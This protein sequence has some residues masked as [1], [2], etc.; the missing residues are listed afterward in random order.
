M[1]NQTAHGV[2]IVNPENGSIDYVNQ[3]VTDRLGYT[4]EELQKKTIDDIAP[5]YFSDEPIS[6]QLNR[7]IDSSPT[8][9]LSHHLTKKNEFI[10]VRMQLDELI[11]GD[12]TYIL[13]MVRELEPINDNGDPEF[14]DTLRSR[15]SEDGVGSNIDESMISEANISPSPLDFGSDL[16]IF[17]EMRDEIYVFD[18]E[19]GKIL[20]AN[21]TAQQRLGYRREELLQMKIIDFVDI[22]ETIDDWHD[23]IELYRDGDPEPVEGRHFPKNRSSYPVEVNSTLIENEGRQYLISI[24][25]DISERKQ[26][27]RESKKLFNAVNDA[28]SVHDLETFRMID[29]NDTIC[30]M[31]GHDRQTILEK[32]V[33]EFSATEDGFTQ[34][35]AQE[36][37]MEASKNE[38]VPEPF[39]WA[40]RT[41]EGEKVWLEVNPILLEYQG[42]K[43]FLALSRDITKRKHN[44]EQLEYQKSILEAQQEAA[45]EGILVISTDG[46][47]LSYNE[48][49][50]ELWKIPDDVLTD[51]D[52]ETALNYVLD[53]LENPD[54][55]LETVEYLYD[56][57]H[58][59]Q[60]DVLYKKNGTVIERFSSPIKLEGTA[61]G[62]VWFFRDIT[63]KQNVKKKLEK[64][65]KEKETL[66]EEVHHRVKNN[67][68]VISSM[69]RLQ[70]RDEGNEELSDAFKDSINRLETMALIHE[71]LYESEHLA[72]LNIPLYLEELCRRLL[73]SHDREDVELN[74]DISDVSLKLEDAIAIGLLINELVT[75]SLEHGLDN[76]EDGRINLSFQEFDDEYRLI[77]RDNGNGLE[78]D[79]DL[80]NPDTTGL[81]I[82]TSL[83]EYDLEGNIEFTN[84]DGLKVTVRFP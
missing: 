44:R 56:N 27:E 33:G 62:R 51:R 22:F 66:L 6:Q 61:F 63:K 11:L 68:Q 74:M 3:T 40:L 55:F 41:A 78:E 48:Q 42:K 28:I 36:I 69:L 52:D 21:K 67:I 81:R 31:L 50:Q 70:M 37:L 57:P 23:R 26:R 18:V 45:D 1:F 82:V 43:R 77:V 65:L 73:E 64:S 12:Q 17:K 7:V 32:G 53:Q 60:R 80:K 46:E 2:Y 29:V 4:R 38:E 16:E 75:N 59:K 8:S 76:Q 35:L 47:I 71:K 9:Q 72:R 39:E 20:E 49:F 58:Q 24:A 79:F 83:A 34:E 14:D 19:T 54:E 10:P 30:E 84:D 25:R 15:H 5:L 13:A